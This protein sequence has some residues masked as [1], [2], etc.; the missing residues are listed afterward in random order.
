MSWI[1]AIKIGIWNAW[2]PALFLVLHPLVM[3]IVDKI[4]G[5][6]NINQKMGEGSA[7]NGKN[8]AIQ[9]PTILMLLLFVYSIFLPMLVNTTWLIIGLVIYAVGVGMFFSSIITVAKTPQGEIFSRGMYR[10]SRHPLYLSFILIFIGISVLT[11]SWLF[12]L[13]A[14]G[15]M[16][17]PLSQVSAEEREC[18]H[19]FGNAY[20]E[21]LNRTPQW[22][23]LPKI[24]KFKK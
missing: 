19:V 10:Y 22:I 15:W 20:E 5:T 7:N 1:P 2:I 14:M 6:G 3:N 9:F 21:Y 16:I 12:L 13:L 11:L 17:F 4:L 8:T 18:R 23:G 24:N